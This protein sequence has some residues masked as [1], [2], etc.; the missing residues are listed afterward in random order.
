M[1]FY[2]KFI[3]S[4]IMNAI[5][6]RYLS[7]NFHEIINPFSGGEFE[8]IGNWKSFVFLAVLFGLLNGILK[9]LIKIITFPIQFIT[10]GLFGFIV[11]AFMLYLLE[12]S[13][14]FLQF[15]DTKLIIVGSGTYLIVGFT[16]S[17]VNGVIHWFED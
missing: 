17:A 4:T 8:I 1:S 12:L 6:F 9:P 3:L 11:N 16:L 14:N 2:K 10:I 7:I 5:I 13:V 15:F